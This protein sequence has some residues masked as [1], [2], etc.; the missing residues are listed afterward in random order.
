MTPSRFS[1]FDIIIKK[2]QSFQCD[3]TYCQHGEETVTRGE[4]EV[5]SIYPNVDNMYFHA[6]SHAIFILLYRTQLK[7][8]SIYSVPYRGG[9]HG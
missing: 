8:Y 5:N 9:E 7:F 1:F 4:A 3:S 6:G 2:L